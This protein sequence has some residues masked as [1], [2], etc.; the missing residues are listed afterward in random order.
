MAIRTREELVS[1]IS[2][3]LNGD[4]S[5]EA[6]ALMEDITDTLTDFETRVAGDGTDWKAEAERIDKE[7]RERY[8]SRFN[9]SEVKDEQNEES[10]DEEKTVKTFE[11]LFEEKEI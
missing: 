9:N 4:T 7:W 2:E 11:D 6:I 3:R 5:D 10:S 1:K 8:I